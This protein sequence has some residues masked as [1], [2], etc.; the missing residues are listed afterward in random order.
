MFTVAAGV[1]GR[2]T[3]SPQPAMP[4]ALFPY[5]TYPFVLATGAGITRLASHIT[6]FTSIVMFCIVY[7]TFTLSNL[8]FSWMPFICALVVQM[9]KEKEARIKEI[10]FIMGFQPRLFWLG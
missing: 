7:L 4:S 9:L 10:M 3:D 5:P 8:M 1:S 2:C 6:C